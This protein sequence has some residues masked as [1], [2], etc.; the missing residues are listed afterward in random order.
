MSFRAQKR[1]LRDHLV[2]VRAELFLIQTIN[3]TLHRPTPT[4]HPQLSLPTTKNIRPTYHI[5]SHHIL[6]KM[7]DSFTER[8]KDMMAFA[9]QCFDDEPKVNWQK[10]AGLMGMSNER[11][12]A[13]AWARIKKKLVQRAAS[14]NTGDNDEDG[15]AAAV[16][17]TPK[18]KVATGKKRGRKPASA[19]DENDDND[20]DAE[21]P[22]KKSRA[23]KA[24]G[25]ARKALAVKDEVDDSAKAIKAEKVEDGDEDEED[26]GF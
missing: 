20:G 21:P 19:A 10:L 12:A 15:S 17:S 7:A 4:P 8:E 23:K 14:A 2:L 26:G 22:V 3:T 25:G 13:N 16:S 6:V 9:W 1:L 5:T 24:N 11:S 18:P